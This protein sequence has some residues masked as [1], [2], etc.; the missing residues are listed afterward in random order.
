MTNFV[1]EKSVM[2]RVYLIWMGRLAFNRYTLKMAILGLLAWQFAAY[3]F[4]QA[5]LDNAA[6]TSGFDYFGYFFGAFTHTHLIT[7]AIV[8]GISVV[9]AWLMVDTYRNLRF[10]NFLSKK[11][12]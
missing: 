7:Q 11:I 4:V 8:L 6:R 2:R 10:S 12:A 5:V 1:L 9:V 3:V